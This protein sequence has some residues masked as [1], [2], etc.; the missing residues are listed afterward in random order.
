MT[1]DL[2]IPGD[3]AAVRSLADWM[4]PEL[5]N[6]QTE[7]QFELMY[8]RADSSTSGREKPEMPS[9]VRPSACIGRRNLST[10]S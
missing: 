5:D 2:H 3:H 7:A 8:L 6:R 4:S 9:G 1:I 10:A